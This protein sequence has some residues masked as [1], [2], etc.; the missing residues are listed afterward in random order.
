LRRRNPPPRQM[1]NVLHTR[2]V[3]A[4]VLALLRGLCGTSRA[5]L[6]TQMRSGILRAVA[7]SLGLG[8]GVVAPG[9]AAAPERTIETKTGPL[10][11]ETVAEGLNRPWSLA[12]LPDGRMLVTERPGRL[13]LITQDGRVSDPLG[14]VPPVL[15]RDQGGLLDVAL[16]PQFQANG[17]IY[18]SYGEAGQ[19]GAT[20]AVAQAKLSDSS[21][22][23]LRVIFRQMPTVDGSKHFGSR[24]A[25]APDGT[26]FVTLGERFKLDQ[27]Q[28]ISN[29]LGAIVRINADGSIPKDNPFVGKKDARPEI[30][31]YGHRNIEAAA[32]NPVT[33]ALWVADMGPVGGDGLVVPEPGKNY[34]WPVVSWGDHFDGR[35]I[36]D[37]PTRPEFA[38]SIHHWTPAISPS[39]MAFYTADLM[40]GWKGSVLIGG[41]SAN[42]IVRLSLEGLKVASEERIAMGARIRDVRQAPDG[43]LHVLTDEENGKLLRLTPTRQGT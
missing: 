19:G 22:E 7:V 25:F 21:L 42:V 34:G 4:V 33:G 1:V 16:D 6:E 43:A 9:L 14:G 29:H 11:V 18:L 3:G 15:G 17:L 26:L 35:E 31:S 30:W 23:N 27:A 36:P 32:I 8:A 41:L 12:Y 2:P 40:P 20:T 13:R 39:G 28:N 37:P 24:L 5:S 10:K 38:D